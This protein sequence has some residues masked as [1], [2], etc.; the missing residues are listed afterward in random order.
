[1]NC[2]DAAG[3]FEGDLYHSA[4]IYSASDSKLKKN[5]V[6]FTSAS[7]I[8]DQLV[9]KTYEFDVKN[10]NGMNLHTG[11]HYGLIAQDVERVLPNLV[12]SFS[13]PEKYDS[14]GNVTASQVDFKA[15]D[16]VEL[17]PI[18]LGAIK[19]QKQ[20]V[21]SL[22]VALN[23]SNIRLNANSTSPQKVVLENAQQIILDQNDPNPF[24]ETTTINYSIPEEVK[25]A[26]IIFTNST[27]VILRS[28]I[29]NERGEGSLEVYGSN[30]SSGIYNYT[31]FIDGKATVTK[32]MV[33][34]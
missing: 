11:M 15:V 4:G 28:I 31:L 6:D 2:T 8:I 24:S 23:T 29:I 17:I 13:S 10:F 19:E 18:L 30:L 34:Q 16:Y 1:M 32:K 9:P 20:I 12:K 21:D 27:G 3:F 25:N 14:I 33:K 26:K 22:L 7:Q 5:I